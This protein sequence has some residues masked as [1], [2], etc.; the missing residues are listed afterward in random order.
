[1]IAKPCILSQF[2]TLPFMTDPL[3][4]PAVYQNHKLEKCDANTAETA[5]QKVIALMKAYGD[6]SRAIV[7]V[8]WLAGNKGHL[9][10]AEN[11]NDAIYFV[12]PQTGSLDVAWYFSYIN[13]HSV[14]VMRTDQ[15]DFTE[16]VKQCLE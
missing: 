7:K 14:V 3:G 8:D 6:R 9:F 4:W 11:R 12:D 16:L 13:P 5:K 1:M 15:T 2:D 10:I